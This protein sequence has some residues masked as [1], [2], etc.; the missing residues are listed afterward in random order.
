[1]SMLARRIPLYLLREAVPL[2]LIGIVTLLLLLLIDYFAFL[3]GYVIANRSPATLILQSVLDRVPFFLS[4]M[5]APALAFALPVGL[6]RLAKDSELKAL[7][8]AGIR[9]LG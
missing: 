7:Y 8:A 9:P 1:M 2:Y 4:Y 3:L 5:L 6:G